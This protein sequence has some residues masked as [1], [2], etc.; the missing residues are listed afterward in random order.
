[1][2][3]WMGRFTV[4][5]IPEDHSSVRRYQIAA[6]RV[7]E[8]AWV[9]GIALVLLVVGSADYV[10]ARRDTAELGTLRI[11]SAADRE[12]LQRLRGSV[13]DLDER[14]QRIRELE[15][16]VRVIADLPRVEN[17]SGAPPPGVGGG[18]DE[19]S[20]GPD[21]SEPNLD[22]GDLPP[23][24][25]SGP[26]SGAKPGATTGASSADRVS[27]VDSISD[28]TAGALAARAARLRLESERLRSLASFQETSLEEL[29]DQ[30]HGKSQRL[31]STPSIWPTKGWVTSG[32]GHRTSPFTG[33]K[34]FH[35]GL[36][37]AS[38]LG[39]EIVAPARGRVVFR[40]RKGPLGN[41][42]VIDHGYGIRTTYGH[43]EKFLVE[44]RQE[45]ER[46]ERIALLGN[47]GRST[48]PHLHYVVQID[49]RS[50]NPRNYIFE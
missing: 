18:S 38:E 45:V 13:S 15:R 41:A 1:M 35:G 43:I 4:L 9:L 49:G 21:P 44:P 2:E 24:S 29:I 16:K 10:R 20:L 3:C 31:A 40:G 47:T 12:E 22:G 30:L 37:I 17:G 26:N 19:P 34:Q 36:D 5:I 14:M 11:E 33:R 48:G 7:R 6:K 39:T 28:D 27:R 42:I 23:D 25:V 32:Y 8:G 46:G 50:V